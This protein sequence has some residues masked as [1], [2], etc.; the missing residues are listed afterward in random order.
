MCEFLEGD[1][2]SLTKRMEAESEEQKTSRNKTIK[3]KQV[4]GR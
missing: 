2:Q 1:R 3:D 4:I